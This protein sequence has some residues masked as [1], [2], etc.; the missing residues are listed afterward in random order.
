VRCLGRE[1]TVTPA[2]STE[3]P[4]H[5]LKLYSYAFE[6][7]TVVQCSGRL[8]L[9]HAARLKTEVKGMISAHKR[10]ILDLAELVFMDSSGLGTIVGL[11]IS[12]RSAGCR[13]EL[14]NMSK[15]IRELMGLSHLLE[16]F[17][18]CGRSGTR[19]P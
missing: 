19:I 5:N 2:E 7:A 17:E 1:K 9:E 6:D 3:L 13:I 15:P 10:I 8:T 4:L 14:M 12:A 11:Y 18:A 16:V